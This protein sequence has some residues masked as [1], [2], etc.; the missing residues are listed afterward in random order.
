MSIGCHS[1]V[2][3]ISEFSGP[4]RINKNTQLHFSIR[5]PRRSLWATLEQ[6]KNKGGSLKI[7]QFRWKYYLKI[8]IQK[9][10]F[11]KWY[12]GYS[13]GKIWQ[14]VCVCVCF[15]KL[16]T[17]AKP[18]HPFAQFLGAFWAG[19]YY[20]RNQKMAETTKN[21]KTMGTWGG[22]KRSEIGKTRICL[23]VRW[24]PKV[25]GSVLPCFWWS[26]PSQ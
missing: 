1:P 25:Y 5:S 23:K 19:G 9:K 4:A 13:G 26:G 6:R 18:P 3:Y 17:A 11:Q 8:V 2:Q 20:R 16:C 10:V 12:L 22:Q 14:T 21:S 24:S 15:S 7:V